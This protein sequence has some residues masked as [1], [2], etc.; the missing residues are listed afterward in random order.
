MSEGCRTSWSHRE[1]R[2]PWD[3]VS[4]VWFL[5][6]E[7]LDLVKRSAESISSKGITRG[8]QTVPDHVS[9]SKTPWTHD[10]N[11]RLRMKELAKLPHG[12]SCP[13]F[14]KDEQRATVLRLKNFGDISYPKTINLS[15]K[16]RIKSSH[17]WR[18][19]ELKQL[20]MSTYVSE[21]VIKMAPICSEKQPWA[22]QLH[23]QKRKSTFLCPPLALPRLQ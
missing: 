4:E 14:T 12:D 1:G 13:W 2:V 17:K 16:V 18:K 9:K 21:A 20:F 6:P 10:C 19:L 5:C 22:N 11:E 23:T 3:N 7:G 8:S 15:F